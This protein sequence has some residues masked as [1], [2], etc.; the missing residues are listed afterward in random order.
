MRAALLGIAPSL[1]VRFDLKR[2]ATLQAHWA[3]FYGGRLDVID[4]D[5]GAP[6]FVA[7]LHALTRN[8]RSLAEVEGWLHAL[9]QEQAP[10][11]EI[12]RFV[13]SRGVP[14]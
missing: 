12:S 8:F 2:F 7:T 14:A 4:G 5:D 11:G 10:R 3:W 6:A 13:E 9:D 1:A